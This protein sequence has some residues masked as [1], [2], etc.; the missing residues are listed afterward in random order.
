MYDKIQ[1]QYVEIKTIPK[2][3]EILKLYDAFQDPVSSN[4]AKSCK[5]STTI[6]YSNVHENASDSLIL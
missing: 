5:N 3:D 6:F 4:W 2:I 1:G